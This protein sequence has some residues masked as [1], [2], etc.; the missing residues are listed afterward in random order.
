MEALKPLESKAAGFMQRLMGELIQAA[1]ARSAVLAPTLVGKTPFLDDPES[2]HQVFRDPKGFDK[3]FSFLAD[4]GENR[5]F[6]PLAGWE[7]RFKLTQK[8]YAKAGRAKAAAGIRQTVDRALDRIKDS[9]HAALRAALHEAAVDIFWQALDSELDPV[10]DRVRELRHLDSMRALSRVLQAL[11]WLPDSAQYKQAAASD[12]RALR[13]ETRRLFE[14]DPA[15]AKLLA[16]L[17]AEGEA[18]IEGFDAV[19]ELQ[20]NLAAGT[21][22]SISG[23]MWGLFR[24]AQFPDAQATI[25]AEQR[26]LEPGAAGPALKV[27]TQE[28]LRMHPPIPLVSRITTEPQRVGGLEIPA[29][30][31]VLISILGLHRK[32]AHWADPLRFDPARRELAEEDYPRFALLPFITDPRTCGGATLA[33]MEMEQGFAAILERFELKLSGEAP[34]L[35]YVITWRPDNLGAVSLTP[36]G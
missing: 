6:T 2:L 1:A 24:L 31:Q 11:A 8:S 29:G 23:L 33:Q 3:D 16:R 17:Q 12:C 28:V 18:E 4:L 14:S 15:S 9:G 22:T 21:E 20:L 34:G 5:V 35:D 25:R 13:E 36:R 26:E 7:P 27:F 32:A 30:A 10:R 19:G